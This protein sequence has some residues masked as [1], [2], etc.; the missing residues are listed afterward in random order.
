MRHGVMSLVALLDC[1]RRSVRSW[2]LSTTM[3]VACCVT[4]LEQALAHGRPEV[5]HTAQ[6]AQVTAVAVTPRVAAAHVAISLEGRGRVCDNIFV[7]R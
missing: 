5:F 6:G 4:A 7:E 2:H 1:Y 3:A